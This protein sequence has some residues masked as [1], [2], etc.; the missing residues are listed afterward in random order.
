MLRPR[1]E[2]GLCALFTFM[3]VLTA[4]WPTW[5]ERLTGIE[6]D[7]GSGATEWGVVVLLAGVALGLGLLAGGN[8][9]LAAPRRRASRGIADWAASENPRRIGWLR[10]SF[11]RI[12]GSLAVA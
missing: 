7:G 12:R 8:Y 6:P 4:V 11:M 9:V 5:I 10:S 2:L 3:T 1:L